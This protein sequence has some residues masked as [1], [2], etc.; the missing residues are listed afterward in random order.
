MNIFPKKQLHVS[1]LYFGTYVPKIY[2]SSVV[3]IPR[4][5]SII[6]KKSHTCY[7]I[8]YFTLLGNMRNAHDIWQTKCN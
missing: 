5:K 6:L 4:E 1:Y 3:R 2:K 8:K 7:Y